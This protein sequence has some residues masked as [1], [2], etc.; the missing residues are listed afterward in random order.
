MKKTFSLIFLLLSVLLLEAA[1]LLLISFNDLWARGVLAML[2]TIGAGCVLLAGGGLYILRKKGRLGKVF[3]GLVLSICIASLIVIGGFAGLCRL[4]DSYPYQGGFSLTTPLFEGKNVMLLI[5]HQDDEIN[6]AGGLIEQYTEKG[7]QVTVVFTTNGDRFGESELRARET[8]SVLTPLGVKAENIFYL[9]FGDLWQPQTHEGKTVSHIYNSPDPDSLWTSELGFTAAYSTALIPCRQELDYTRSNYLHSIKS[10]LLERKPDTVFVVDMDSH[11]DHI[12]ASLLFEEAMGQILKEN[13][14]Y[15][16]T[17]YKGFC[18]GTAWDAWSD[19]F[20]DANL[21]STQ[22]PFDYIWDQAG[23]SYLWENRLRFPMSSTNLNRVLSNNSVYESLKQHNSQNAKLHAI[24]V[25]NGDKVFWERRTDSLLYGA[26]VT[27]DEEAT[28]LLNDFKL[29]DYADISDLTGPNTNCV[30]VRGKTVLIQ[31]PTLVT[32]NTLCLYQNPDA[33]QNNWEGT[34][35]LSD[36]TEISLADGEQSDNTLTLRFSDAQVSSLEITVTGEEGELSEVELYREISKPD[37]DACIMAVDSDDNFV[38][39]Y[40]LQDTD[41]LAL[42]LCSYPRETAL[43]AA[44]VQV[45]F[46][47]SGTESTYLWDGDLLVIFC[48]EKEECRIRVSKG[49]LQTAFT[50]SNPGTAHRLYEKLLRDTDRVLLNAEVLAY[51]MRIWFWCLVTGQ[52][53]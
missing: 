35:R 8:L 24:Q 23:T 53:F 27:V 32:A 46:T 44:D 10:I 48:G 49:D 26:E 39:D 45:S 5:P 50:V 47:A 4:A 14:G 12:A 30:D 42:R 22:K 17:V 52:M 3:S 19:Y 9:G 7:S 11:L 25:L 18:Y 34:V 6:L 29:R 21:L 36:G 31:L 16:P 43:T 51:N 1:S 37:T 41:T 13:P 15:R 28:A 40:I 38:Y 33:P 20:G 2:I